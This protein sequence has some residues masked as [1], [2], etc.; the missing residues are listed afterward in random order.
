MQEFEGR[1]TASGQPVTTMTIPFGKIRGAWVEDGRKNWHR[2]LVPSGPSQLIKS[3]RSPGRYA[4]RDKIIREAHLCAKAVGDDDSEAAEILDIVV[5]L[6]TKTIRSGTEEEKTNMQKLLTYVLDHKEAE[7][8]GCT[9][10]P[11]CL[12]STPVK[13]S[14]KPFKMTKEEVE[15]AESTPMEAEV[16]GEDIKE[17]EASEEVKMET[18]EADATDQFEEVHRDLEGFSFN[19]DEVDYDDDEEEGMEVE[20]EAGETKLRPMDETEGD[21][22]VAGDDDDRLRELAEERVRAQQERDSRYP[23]WAHPLKIG[24]KKMPEAHEGVS[25][26]DPDEVSPQI[27][28][29]TLMIFI[30]G[31]YE[32]YYLYRT[33]TPPETRYEWTINQGDRL[34][35][36]KLAPM[37]GF[38][39]NGD[40]RPPTTSTLRPWFDKKAKADPIHDNEM[41]WEGRPFESMM[42]T[43]ETAIKIEKIMAFLVETGLSPEKIRLV[44]PQ[45]T[46]P[47]E[48]LAETARQEVLEVLKPQ[49]TLEAVQGQLRAFFQRRRLR[50]T[51]QCELIA[52]RMRNV[53]HWSQLHRDGNAAALQRRLRRL[54]REIEAADARIKRLGEES[55]RRKRPEVQQEEKDRPIPKSCTKKKL[56]DYNEVYRET[57]STRI[58]RNDLVVCLREMV[59]ND[60]TTR[61]LRR[62]LLQVRHLPVTHRQELW[63]STLQLA[64]KGLEEGDAL[65][66]PMLWQ[67]RKQLASTLM[68][69]ARRMRIPALLEQDSGHTLASNVAKMFPEIFAKQEQELPLMLVVSAKVYRLEDAWLDLVPLQPH[70]SLH[71]QEQRDAGQRSAWVKGL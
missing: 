71:S 1:V 58:F 56:F 66:H 49:H 9:V 59:W 50:L 54:S 31:Y 23:K 61:T 29:N 60:R 39:D 67:P 69:M 8:A 46:P 70:V 26:I 21:D 55:T 42:M 3:V 45:S 22:R 6:E 47:L 57:A 14:M 4:T 36:D 27:L 13:L 7:R 40:L 51:L 68:D 12:L 30:T 34:D 48:L 28:D 15:E 17:E 64:Q 11:A 33:E 52:S 63:R 2:L 44:M 18:D 37:N 24:T 35:L 5:G 43:I 41:L 53:R 20:E 19:T 16:G 25:N 38:D 65:R 32:A 10:C 62:F